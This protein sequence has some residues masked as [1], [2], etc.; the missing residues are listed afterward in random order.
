MITLKPYQEQA[1]DNLITAL[2]DLLTNDIHDQEIC[3]FQSPTGSGK[4]VMVAK[5]I[6]RL[7]DELP[8]LDLCFI[9]VSIGKG[10]LHKQSK[11][12]LSKIFCGF[13]ITNLA[14]DLFPGARDIINRNEVIVVNWESIRNQDKEGNWK[15]VMMKDGEKNNLRDVITNTKKTGRQIVLIIDEAHIG[16]GTERTEQL[17]EEFHPDSIIEMSATPK[18]IKVE[19]IDLLR[20]Q[21]GLI[22]KFNHGRSYY[23]YVNSQDVIDQEMIK[24]ELIINMDI[25]DKIEESDNSFSLI[26]K[27]GYD[28]QQ[29]LVKAFKDSNININ[30]LTLIQIPNAIKGNELIQKIEQFLS[31]KGFTEENGKVAKWLSEEKSDCLNTITDNNSRV[32]F[33]IFKQAI[34]TGWDCPRASILIKFRETNSEIF[35]IQTVGRILRM[36]EQKHYSD[37]RLNKGYIFSNTENIIIAYEKYNPNIIKYHSAVR[38]D[39]YKSPMISSYYKHRISYNDIGDSFKDVFFDQACKYLNII[40]TTNIELVKESLLKAG[41]DLTNLSVNTNIITDG[42]MQVN[43]ITHID[44]SVTKADII[45]TILSD[46]ELLHEFEDLIKSK[47]KKYFGGVKR[48]I[49]AVKSAIYLFFRRVLA[50]DITEIVNIVCKYKVIFIDNILDQALIEYKPVRDAEVSKKQEEDIKLFDIIEKEYYSKEDYEVPEKYVYDK[51]Y[52]GTRSNPEIS[53]EKFI[54]DYSDNIDWWW[55]NG[56]SGKNAFGIKYEY[57]DK[58]YTFYPDYLVRF[59]DGW[60]GLFEVKHQTDQ[61]GKTKTKAKAEALYDYISTNNNKHLIG[62]ICIE[63]DSIWKINSNKEYKCNEWNEWI[64]L[65][66]SKNED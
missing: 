4:T 52:Y 33:L 41:I 38:V 17:L 26:L 3:V 60:I 16:Q 1:V 18:F 21:E 65:E 7:I 8:D 64:N 42:I 59:I 2:S 45:N 32:E 31:E 24:D 63:V 30:P 23:V 43:D 61:D 14:E 48:S 53:F 29:E 55:K 25:K 66:Y 37:T 62:G 5:F 57:D 20:S 19:E 49:S 54:E 34:D 6:E 15:N 13:P 50:V 46:E 39:R 36:P 56:S 10:E 11:N 12:K 27:S 58:T 44:N 47:I 40:D 28:K 51:Y 9:W 35:E 22:H